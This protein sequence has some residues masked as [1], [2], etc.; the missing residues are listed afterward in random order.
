MQDSK[1]KNN[2]S[3]KENNSSLNNSKNLEQDSDSL[4][5]KN[6]KQKQFKREKKLAKLLKN[7][8]IRRKEID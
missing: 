2:H 6:N 1:I 4:C 7:N 8:L 3:D 5:K